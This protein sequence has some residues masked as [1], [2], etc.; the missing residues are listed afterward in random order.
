MGA[1]DVSTMER[2]FRRAFASWPSY[3]DDSHA[4]AWEA[5]LSLSVEDRSTA[6]VSVERYAQACRAGDTKRCAFGVYLREKRWESLPPSV[7]EPPSDYAPPFGPVWGAFLIARLLLGDPDNHVDALYRLAR[8]RRGHRFGERW[9]AMK[10]LMVAVPVASPEL[11]AWRME[12]ERRGWP[13]LPDPGQQ[14]V[15]YFPAGGPEAL[16][17]FEKAIR[18]TGNDSDRREAAE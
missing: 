17:A 9:Q 2:A 14:R 3:V 12:F 7:D 11:E 16:D 15:V 13:W 1:H 10:P 6:A 8:I 4:A 5:W 18:G